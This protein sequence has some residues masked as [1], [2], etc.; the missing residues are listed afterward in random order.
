MRVLAQEGMD[1]FALHADPTA[2]NNAD[3]PETFLDGLLEVLFDDNPYLL[4]LKRVE[5]DAVFDRY[6]M[7]QLPV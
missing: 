1:N 4:W 6:A 3:F 2:V 7:H 5:I